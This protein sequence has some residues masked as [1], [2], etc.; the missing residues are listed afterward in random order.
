MIN[1]TL[2]ELQEDVNQWLNEYNSERTHTGKYCY[3]KTPFQTFEAA[4]HIAQKKMILENKISLQE[5]KPERESTRRQESEF[6]DTEEVRGVSKKCLS[7]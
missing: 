7:D 1:P 4:K 2:E 6:E 5:Q 3:G